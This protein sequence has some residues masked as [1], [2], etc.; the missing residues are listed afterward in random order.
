MIEIRSHTLVL[1]ASL[2]LM[3][4]MG[5]QASARAEELPGP[6]SLQS[7][8]ASVSGNRLQLAL[9]TGFRSGDLRPFAD[10]TRDVGWIPRLTASLHLGGVAGVEVDYAILGVAWREGSVDDRNSSQGGVGSGD[11]SLLSRFA[12][13]KRDGLIPSISLGFSVKL[14]DADDRE[15]FGTDET[16][17]WLEAR[18][19]GKARGVRW[20]GRV[21]FGILGDPVARAGQDDVWSFSLGASGR[22]PAGPDLAA[23]IEGRLPSPLN[24]GEVRAVGL[25]GTSLGRGVQI[26]WGAEAG[27]AGEGFQWGARTE[28]SWTGWPTKGPRR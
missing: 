26:W 18:V 6:A 9:G 21:A 28:I 11:V 13:L 12:V 14:P 19:S 4:G 22:V 7:R 23:E 10:A 1:L 27:V 20:D 24:E 16:D 15:G 3:G 25:L 8:D 2:A 17:L 5:C